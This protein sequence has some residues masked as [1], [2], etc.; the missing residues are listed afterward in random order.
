MD[1]TPP[2]LFTNEELRIAVNQF[3]KSVRKYYDPKRWG[4]TAEKRP[5]VSEHLDIS[6]GLYMLDKIF[7]ESQRIRW[8]EANKRKRRAKK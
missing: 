7:E 8:Y 3:L 6:Q 4:L 2:V 1:N 5:P